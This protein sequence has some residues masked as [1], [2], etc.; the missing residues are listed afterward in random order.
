[1]FDSS[2]PPIDPNSI[3]C[4]QFSSFND[5]LTENGCQRFKLEAEQLYAY[6]TYA[7]S[8]PEKQKKSFEYLS[9]MMYLGGSCLL[10]SE[11]EKTALNEITSLKEDLY[12][13]VISYSD[14][15]FE[16]HLHQIIQRITD[17]NPRAKLL[18][19]SMELE[20]VL[21]LHVPQGIFPL[22]VIECDRL[23]SPLKAKVYDKNYSALHL[24]NLSKNIAIIKEKLQ[25]YPE[26]RNHHLNLL[27]D[28]LRTC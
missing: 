22:D 21:L 9:I 8:Q 23:L 16:D 4:P 19:L 12:G 11:E 28:T 14:P 17:E 13:G 18:S 20:Y 25:Q 24:T 27:E 15:H 7:T 10:K 5:H 2:L 1:M 6:I 3:T 26:E